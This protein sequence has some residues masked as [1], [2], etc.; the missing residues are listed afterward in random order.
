MFKPEEVDDIIKIGY[1]NGLFVLAR[2]IGLIGRH[3][4]PPPPTVCLQLP[5]TMCAPVER[6]LQPLAL[7][8]LLPVAGSVL[9]RFPNV[10]MC[11]QHPCSIPAARNNHAREERKVGRW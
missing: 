2:S 3:R 9:A 4:F 8:A 1:L 10:R 6:V 5:L 11:M 7:S